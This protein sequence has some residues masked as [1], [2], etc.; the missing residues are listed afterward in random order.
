MTDSLPAPTPEPS[1]EVLLYQPED[2]ITRIEVR[3][4]GDTVWLPQ[5]AMADLFQTT[6]QNVSLHI[7]NIFEEGELSPEATVKQYLTEPGRAKADRAT[8]KGP[9]KEEA[10]QEQAQEEETEAERRSFV[11]E[12]KGLGVTAS[13]HSKRNRACKQQCHDSSHYGLSAFAST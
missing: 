1:G 10:G 8:E 12:D 5:R 6:K 2:G 9:A 7:Q 4:E 3:L 11:D 13:P